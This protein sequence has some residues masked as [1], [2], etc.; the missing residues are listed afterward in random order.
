MR[1]LVGAA[2]LLLTPALWSALVELVGLLVRSPVSRPVGAGL[3][4]GALIEI[5]L[6]RRAPVLAVAEHELTHA[7]VALA[8]LRPVRGSG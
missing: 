4:A 2:C 1:A 8:F 7:V 5:I 3:L 6:L